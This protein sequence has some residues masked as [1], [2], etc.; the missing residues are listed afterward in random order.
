MCIAMMLT[1]HFLNILQGMVMMPHRLWINFSVT[2]IFQAFI[3]AL[4]PPENSIWAPEPIKCQ[5]KQVAHYSPMKKDKSMQSRRREI[6]TNVVKTKQLPYRILSWNWY[7]L[8]PVLSGT[9]N[10]VHTWRKFIPSLIFGPM[11]FC[12][13][14]HGHS[15]ISVRLSG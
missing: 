1:K 2:W 12:I 9:L 7:T 11:L 4:P 5:W 6:W 15:I 13:R 8:E 10:Y 3:C 14:V